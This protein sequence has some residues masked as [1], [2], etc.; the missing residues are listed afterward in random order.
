[1]MGIVVGMLHVCSAS[2]LGQAFNA[3]RIGRAGA[4]Y[5]HRARTVGGAAVG[6][7]GQGPAD[8]PG[9]P[10]LRGGAPIILRPV[11]SFGLS[12]TLFHSAV[13]KGMAHGYNVCLS[14]C[15]RSTCSARCEFDCFLHE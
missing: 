13:V 5:D 3:C 10:R 8:G 7:D 1:M 12:M 6:G 15:E 9:E 2:I 14:L 4:A 11:A